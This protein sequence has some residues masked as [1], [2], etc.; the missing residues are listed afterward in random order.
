MSLLNFFSQQSEKRADDLKREQSAGRSADAW[1]SSLPEGKRPF[2]SIE[3]KNK[4]AA[5]RADIM[6]GHIAGQAFESAQLRMESERQQIE[7][8]RQRIEGLKQEL[9]ADRGLGL[10]MGAAADPNARYGLELQ[11]P[12][13]PWSPEMIAGAP[14]D[15]SRAVLEAMAQYPEAASARNAPAMLN[16]LG[17]MESA[18]QLGRPQF[19]EDPVSGERFAIRGRTMIPSG[20]NPNNPYQVLNRRNVKPAPI[21]QNEALYSDDPEEVKAWL[22]S[23]PGERRNE[24]LETLKD[25]HS[26][27][28]RDNPMMRMISE[29]FA[30]GMGSGGAAGP[31]AA[32]KPAPPPKAAPAATQ[33]RFFIDTFTDGSQWKIEVLP[34]GSERKIERVR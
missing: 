31:G 23:L 34:D 7:S 28:G 21:E 5:E 24:A 4:S 3:F 15:R 8:E 11:N 26:G 16:A 13:G 33:P 29:V 2:D 12:Q 17:N 18:T 30:R 1:F 20:G 22:K 32:V 10:A 6:K 19:E 9:G 25:L 27:L 14:R